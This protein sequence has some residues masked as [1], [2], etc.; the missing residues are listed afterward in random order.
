MKMITIANLN[1][2]IEAQQL[3]ARLAASG[4]EA[5]IPDEVSAGVVPLFFVTKGGVRV[6]VAE[7][8]EDEARAIIEGDDAPEEI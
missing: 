5:F 1:S 8:V 2:L 4:I 7:E 6:Q 3:K